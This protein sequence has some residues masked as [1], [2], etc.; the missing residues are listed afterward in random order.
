MKTTL[1]CATITY[2]AW[3]AFPN[4]GAVL[5]ALAWVILFGCLSFLA[6]IGIVLA[7]FGHEE[8]P[9]PK[10]T[11]PPPVTASDAELGAWGMQAI[12]EVRA[13]SMSKT[14]AE[15]RSLPVVRR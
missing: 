9:A 10:P 3:A 4:F 14:L 11:P 1:T 6:A 13:E 7:L 15:I 5:D 8:M 2:V 12:R